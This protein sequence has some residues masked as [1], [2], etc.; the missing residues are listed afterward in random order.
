MMD[1]RWRVSSR[2]WPLGHNCSAP[3][4]PVSKTPLDFYH[5]GGLM[6]L[7]ALALLG[8]YL[9]ALPALRAAIEKEA[10]PPIVSDRPAVEA[11]AA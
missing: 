4:A 3:L 2:R 5:A 6:P 11:R 1:P 8:S 9:T 7:S 10:V